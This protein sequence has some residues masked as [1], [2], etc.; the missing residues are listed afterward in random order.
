M[1][2]SNSYDA[3]V[4]GVGGMGSATVYQ[5]SRRGLRVLGLEQF[6]IPHDY[7]S[8]HGVNRIIRLAYFEHPNY[9]PML[10]RAYELWREIEN[11]SNERLLVITGSIDAS[12]ASKGIV[13]SSQESCRLHN[14]PYELLDAD[15]LHRR[16]PAFV[17]PD[18]MAALYQPDGGFVLSERAIVS[19]VSAAQTLG[20]E[21]HACEPVLQ[22]QTD[23]S[24]VQV[25]TKQ[26][27]YKA[28]K[29]VITAGPWAAQL[30]PKLAATA[31]AQ[32]QVLLW[33]Q[34]L[35]P[36]L[37]RLGAFPVFNLETTFG[38][39][40]G[41]PIYGVPGFKIGKFYHRGEDVDPD[42]VDRAIHPQDEEVLRQ[43]LRHFFPDADG[44]TM[45]MK[46]CLFT[47]TP[48]KHFI[49]DVLPGMPQIA[50]AAGFSGHGFK[51]SS[52]VG[53]LMAD[54]IMSGTSRFDLG[55]FSI[56]RFI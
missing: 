29:L 31:I 54:L 49:L 44:P 56:R 42:R 28:A 47:N 30:L 10:R 45:A 8:S 1:T 6:S 5:L 36:K 15:E 2:R 34:P 51:F 27:E 43:P 52:V 40:Y 9:V 39:F 41:F 55:M 37:F 16:F 46:T 20:A 18:N 17:L 38:H 50:I 7:G 12:D 22:W 25:I 35:E 26:G 48:D 24:G 3:I 11:I 23:G 32:R 21:I 13:K 4:I 33:A 19:Y 14:L 53:E